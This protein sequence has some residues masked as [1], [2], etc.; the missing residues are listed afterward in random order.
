MESN[1]LKTEQN[2]VNFFEL[3]NKVGG[4]ERLRRKTQIQSEIF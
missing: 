2:L 3:R 4:G 1:I